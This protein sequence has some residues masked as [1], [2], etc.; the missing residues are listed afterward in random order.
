MN[1]EVKTRTPLAAR[2]SATCLFVV[3]AVF[4]ARTKSARYFPVLKSSRPPWPAGSPRDSDA[5]A[6]RLGPGT[7]SV[8]EA[9][10]NR[11]LREDR[12]IAIEKSPKMADLLRA[13]FPRAIIITGDAFQLDRLL[14]QHA[15]QVNGVGT[16]FCSLPLRNFRARVADDLAK[17]V[18]SLLLPGGR[19][20]QIHL[21]H[22]QRPAQGRRPFPPHPLLASSG[23]MSR[24]PVSVF[25]RSKPGRARQVPA[26]P[27]GAKL[28]PYSHEPLDF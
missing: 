20:V 17:K 24:K 27:S 12:L 3:E 14:K 1:A 26:M 7:G 6:A 16:V 19:L 22:R 5:Y 21:S 25:T 9:L 23:S 4:H 11:G 18:R 15:P 2:F 10:I 28:I 8:T 13:R